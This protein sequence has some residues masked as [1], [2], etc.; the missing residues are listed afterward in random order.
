MRLLLVEK[1]LP[2]SSLLGDGHG[3]RGVTF[4]PKSGEYKNVLYWFHGLGDTA[5]GWADL[6]ST[7]PLQK[8][9]V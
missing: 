2:N 3:G 9:K 4:V 7:F 5:D 8:T 1:Y 6:V